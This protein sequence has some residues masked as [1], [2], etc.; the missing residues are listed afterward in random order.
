[1]R[2]YYY[3]DAAAA[4]A[5]VALAMRTPCP[6]GIF[7]DVI[8]AHIPFASSNVIRAATRIIYV[9]TEG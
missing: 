4:A 7:P 1:M 3:D 5:V 9:N 6:H 2:Y 8:V